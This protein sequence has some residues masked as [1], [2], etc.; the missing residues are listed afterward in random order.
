M[1]Q[2]M[3]TVAARKEARAWMGQGFV[4]GY[5]PEVGVW[6]GQEIVTGSRKE[7]GFRWG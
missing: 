3:G 5:K 7:V 6:M 1:G 4:M 2:E